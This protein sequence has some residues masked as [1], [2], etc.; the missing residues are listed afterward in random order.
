[1]GS[2]NG[3][4][5]AMEVGMQESHTFD[6]NIVLRSGTTYELRTGTAPSDFLVK[7]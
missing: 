6:I 4:V 2:V 1:M 5:P 3:T 7:L